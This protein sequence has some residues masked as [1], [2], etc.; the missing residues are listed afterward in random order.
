MRAREVMSSEVGACMRQDDGAAAARIMWERDCGTVPVVDGDRRVV[1]IVTDRDLCMA[2]YT[3]G[4]RLHE[5]P[6]DSV[7]TVDPTT[8]AED[9]EIETVEALMAEA[10][11]RR[12]PVVDVRGMLRG[13]VSLDDIAR[14]RARSRGPLDDVTTTLA[15]ICERRARPAPSSAPGATA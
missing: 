10:Q 11:V 13:I 8:C 2:V 3:R 5:I 12:V 4:A 1:G 6:V 9:D 15:A 7:M 14:A